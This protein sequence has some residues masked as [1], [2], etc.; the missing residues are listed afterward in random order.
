MSFQS[1]FWHGRGRRHLYSSWRSFRE[2]WKIIATEKQK[3]GTENREEDPIVG[4]VFDDGLREDTGGVI[5]HD[6]TFVGSWMFAS[7]FARWPR[8]KEGR[9]CFVLPGCCRYLRAYDIFLQ[10]V[11]HKPEIPRPWGESVWPWLACRKHASL[12]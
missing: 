7:I 1:I 12:Q 2:D 9:D 6:L 8:R 5:L 3:G 4:R 10:Q 11:K